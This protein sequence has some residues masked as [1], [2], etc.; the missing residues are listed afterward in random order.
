MIAQADPATIRWT[1]GAGLGLILEAVVL[2][3]VFSDLRRTLGR[4]SPTRYLRV[5][6]GTVHGV[7]AFVRVVL[8][9]SLFVVGV[10]VLAEVSNVRG[11]IL[12]LIELVPWLLNLNATVF[13][14]GRTLIR[15]REVGASPQEGGSMQTSKN[16]PLARA[17]RTFVAVLAASAV[18]WAGIDFATDWRPGAVIVTL[19]VI[20]AAIAAAISFALAMADMTASSALGKA[21][22][23]LLQTLAAGLGTV[24]VNELTSAALVNAGKALWAAV[25]TA[26]VAAVIS[27]VTNASEDASGT[28]KVVAPT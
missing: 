24:V 10:L 23:T 2:W 1:I 28:A 25:T 11:T 6:L 26:V 13:I 21:F 3:M 7:M 5:V 4:Q 15:K 12:F 20:A 9:L 18:S 17:V 14:L 19:N 16:T 22:A 27:Y 8:Q